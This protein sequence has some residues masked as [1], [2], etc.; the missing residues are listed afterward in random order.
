MKIKIPKLKTCPFCG[1]FSAS[2]KETEPPMQIG[3]SFSSWY[4]SC[5]HCGASGPI[6]DSF[7]EGMRKAGLRWNLRDYGQSED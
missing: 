7:D 5:D 1:L 2:Y 4:V 3:F 6:G